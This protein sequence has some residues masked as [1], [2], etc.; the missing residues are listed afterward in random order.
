M[1][2]SR[3]GMLI[4]FAAICLLG[5]CVGYFLFRAYDSTREPPLASRVT[6]TL[7]SFGL[8]PEEPL[9]MRAPA[10][11]HTSITGGIVSGKAKR[12]IVVVQP[13]E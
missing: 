1:R 4:A 2:T 12:T 7:R 10:R 5:F 13:K 8:I 3:A 6:S 11:I 9:V